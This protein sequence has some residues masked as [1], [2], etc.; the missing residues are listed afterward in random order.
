VKRKIVVEL[1]EEHEKANF[2]T[3]RFEGEEISEFDKFYNTFNDR[4]KFEEDLDRIV[5]WIDKIGEQG[6]LERNFRPEGGNLKALL[7]KT[8]ELRLYCFKI[9]DGILILGNGGIK[10]TRTHNEDPVL[11]LHAEKILRKV[12]LLLM[13]RL[14]D[15]K[16]SVHNNTLYGNLIFEIDIPT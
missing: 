15:N 12:G 10:R 4:E 6:V 14:S 2:Y 3:I 16:V 8:P 9:T 1:L 11:N 13:S 5:Y 7:L